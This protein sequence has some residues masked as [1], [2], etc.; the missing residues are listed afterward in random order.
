MYFG[1][2][3]YKPTIQA[4]TGNHP[5]YTNVR[6]SWSLDAAVVSYN[7]DKWAMNAM[8]AK[9]N[10]TFSDKDQDI[11]IAGFDVKANITNNLL[12]QA[13]MY[14]FRSGGAASKEQHNGFWGVKPSYTN[15]VIMVSAEMAKNYADQ[16]FGKGS[17]RIRHPGQL[18]LPRI[19]PDRHD[20][21][22]ERG[23]KGIVLE[24]NPT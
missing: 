3:H 12:L 11:S 9:L 1:P 17:R 18:C 7:G 8:Y 13:Y 21:R 15:D 16:V 10:E 24:N 6:D 19:H 4:P 5:G 2:T 20:R 14:D 23:F 22:D